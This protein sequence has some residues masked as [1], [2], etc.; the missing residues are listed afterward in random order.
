MVQ[1]YN[2]IA[3]LTIPTPFVV[4]DVHVYVI[5]EE[6]LTLVDTGP[7]TKEA[8]LSLEGQLKELGIAP[9]DIKQIVLTHHHPDHA[10]LIDRF[11]QAV[12][13]GAAETNRFLVREDAFMEMHDTFYETSFKE[14]GVPEAYFVLIEKM[15][16]PLQAL[17]QRGLDKTVAPHDFVPGAREWK[18]IETPGHAQG[19]ISLFRERDGLLIGGDMLLAK[20]SSNPLIEPPFSP[21]EERPIPQLQYNESLKKLLDL[22]ISSV[23]PGHG[24]VVENAHTLIH[25]RLKKQHE[26][27][28]YVKQLLIEK[29][30]TAFELCVALFP[31]VYRKQLGLT[32]SET[33]AQIDYLLSIG[34][35][36][37]V[38]LIGDA[39]VYRALANT[40]E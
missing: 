24:P 19:H 2:G 12:V 10:G 39:V 1:W 26:R 29:E 9:E 6:K 14:I 17:G 35:I 22:P 25:Q 37:Q 32:L 4:G 31:S 15:R 27:A 30:A 3:Q 36:E 8:W 20:V 5:K 11:D 34:E 18:V 21:Q 40:K 23:L 38:D 7:K 16:E 33:M 13:L 28:C